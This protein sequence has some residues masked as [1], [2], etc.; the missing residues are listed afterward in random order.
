MLVPKFIDIF[1]H[2]DD[3]INDAYVEII[4]F[5]FQGGDIP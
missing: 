4:N 1:A 5:L 3:D 2:V